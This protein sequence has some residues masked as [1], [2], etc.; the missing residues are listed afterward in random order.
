VLLRRPIIR[1][2]ESVL[3]LRE[4]GAEEHLRPTG[5]GFD[6]GNKK[7]PDCSGALNRTKTN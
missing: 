3:G 1:I 6:E 7:A 2:G 4:D 5:F